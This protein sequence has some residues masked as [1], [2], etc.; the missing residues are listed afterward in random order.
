MTDKGKQAATRAAV[1]GS[2]DNGEIWPLDVY[3]HFGYE[4]DGFPTGQ[5]TT[6]YD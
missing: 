3:E 5:Y 2:G 4:D 1:I 6:E